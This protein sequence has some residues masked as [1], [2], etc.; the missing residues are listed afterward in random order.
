MNGLN[1][2]DHDSNNAI[3][4]DLNISSNDLSYES[5]KFDFKKYKNWIIALVATVLVF[6]AVIALINSNQNKV[7]EQLKEVSD[8]TEIASNPDDVPSFFSASLLNLENEA[9]T[10]VADTT[11]PTVESNN[12]AEVFNFEDEFDFAALDELANTE[13]TAGPV[14]ATET[15]TETDPFAINNNDIAALLGS[16]TTPDPLP[17]EVTEESL[18]LNSNTLPEAM[19]AGSMQGDTGPA[20]WF[21]LIPSIA[22]GLIRKKRA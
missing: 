10:N 8:N 16:S 17:L 6:V 3:P 7:E 20:L 5:A 11:P 18:G 21:A 9:P 13:T 15:E 1:I 19:M 14:I 2:E 12:E 4:E 22:Y